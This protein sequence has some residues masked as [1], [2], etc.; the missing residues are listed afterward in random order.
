VYESIL[1]KRLQNRSFKEGCHPSIK[2]ETSKSKNMNKVFIGSSVD[3]FIADKEG[4]LDWLHSIPNPENID[5]GYASFMEGIDALVMG[6]KSFE[7]VSGFIPWPYEKPV[8]VLSNQLESLPDGFT[9]KAFLLKG[10]LKEVL[11]KIHAK[12][13]FNLYI[14]GGQTIRSFLSADLIDEMIITQIPYLLGGGTPLFT[15]LPRRL[16]FQC[17]ESKIFLNS[18][19]Q[20]RFKRKPR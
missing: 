11:S 7:T 2:R 16:E 5:M 1:E 3:G 9:D 10:T 17:V 13:Y 12:G 6:R 8:F 18:V 4:K 15:E 20:N 14:D 19:V